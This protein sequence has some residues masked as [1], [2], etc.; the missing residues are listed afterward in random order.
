[1]HGNDLIALIAVVSVVALL[2]L[3]K[4]P[5]GQAIADRLRGA[6]PPDPGVLDELEAVKTRLAE[7]EERLDFAERMLAQ[8]EQAQRLPGRGDP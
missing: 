2:K 3:L 6:A 5:L 4:G 8:G 7:V 1:M